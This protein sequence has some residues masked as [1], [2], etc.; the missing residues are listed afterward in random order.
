MGLDKEDG[1]LMDKKER[2]AFLCKELKA[3]EKIT[4]MTEGERAALREWVAAGN[5]VHEN[6]CM[7]CYGGGAPCSFLDV[8]RHDEE[9]RDDLAKLG[10]REQEMYLA[11]LCGEVTIDTLQEDV[12]EL[13]LKA[14]TYHRVLSRHGLEKEAM[15]MLRHAREEARAPTGAM[16]GF[17]DFLTFDEEL[18]FTE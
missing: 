4:P 5:S 15:E 3:Y 17:M 13:R 10:P 12:G 11:R 2:R 6:D 16:A 7:A 18:P 14:D 8:Y 1:C 9:I